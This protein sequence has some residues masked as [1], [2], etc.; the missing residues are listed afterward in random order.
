MWCAAGW[1]VVF[2]VMPMQYFLGYLIIKNK[3]ENAVNTQERGAY[4]QEL[5]PAMKLVKYYAWE[6]FFLKEVSVVSTHYRPCV[7][8][9][10]LCTECYVPVA[11]TMPLVC[12]ACPFVP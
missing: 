11:R 9:Q 1:G 7:T 10:S 4:F 5:L 2:V 12:C 3:K 6:Q 8:R